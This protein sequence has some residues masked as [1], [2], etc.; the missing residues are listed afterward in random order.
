MAL[1]LSAAKS[2]TKEEAESQVKDKITFTEREHTVMN[3]VC[4]ECRQTREWVFTQKEI[5]LSQ[6]TWINKV[7]V[8]YWRGHTVHEER[9]RIFP[10][11]SPP[12]SP[13]RRHPRGGG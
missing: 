5:H 9:Q 4:N 1:Q 3:L 13:P 7:L 11:P 2:P 10:T 8:L 6:R 12:P